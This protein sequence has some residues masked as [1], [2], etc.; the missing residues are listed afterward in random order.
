[1]PVTQLATF[2]VGLLVMTRGDVVGMVLAMVSV[3]LGFLMQIAVLYR[4]YSRAHAARIGIIGYHVGCVLVGMPTSTHPTWYPMIPI[5][6]ACAL[7]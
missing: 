2:G 5:L 3:A 1:M 7:E 6:A 4:F